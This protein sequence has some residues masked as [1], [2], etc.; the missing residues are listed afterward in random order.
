LQVA[1]H[2][3]G[4]NV[5]QL[6]LRGEYLYT[7]NGPGGLRVYDVASVDN[8]GFSE[9]LVTA[10][11]SPLG[12]RTY[13]KT[14]FATAV[15][16]P[17]TMPVDPT[18]CYRDNKQP[19]T[20][21]QPLPPESC[22]PD[23]NQEQ[24]MHELYRYAYVT[25][26]VEGLIVVN[27]DTLADRDPKNNF[28]QRAVTFNPDGILNGAVNLTIAGHYAYILCARGLVVVSIDKPL[29]PR[30]VA[31]LGPPFLVHPR[32]L[33]VQF[34][35]AFVLDAE[36]FKVM[37]IT[38][39]E[40]PREVPGA[41]LP[42]AST[43]DLYVARTYAYVAAGPQGL[44]I[45]DIERPEA[46]S[47]VQTYNADGRLNDAQSVRVGT[48]NASLFAYVADGR[49]GLRVVQLTSPEITSCSDGFS[50][51]PVPHLISTYR[52]RGPALALSKGLDRDRAVDESGNQVSVFGRIGSRPFTLAEMQRLYLKNGQVYT[53]TDTLAGTNLPLSP[54]SADC[55]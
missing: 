39:P 7:A 9:H 8:K 25:D 2:H 52:T 14:A 27:V 48:T 31:E 38:F 33:A 12:Q 35:Y 54:T 3:S 51:R 45:V 29:Q 53:V 19:V 30:V 10:P 46:P 42:L 20:P 15:A 5:L 17:T 18:R 55:K 24:R 47:I 16:L 11:V 50:P 22:L 6:Q 40:Q 43:N 13:V 28:L 36:G 34:R 4:T 37:D 21:M 1:H 32:A 26:K 41:T 44:M 49:N 23:K